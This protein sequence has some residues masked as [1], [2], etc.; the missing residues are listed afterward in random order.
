MKDVFT[1]IG[2]FSCRERYRFE[3]P[4]QG[5]F[6]DN[7]GVIVLNDDPALIEAC[8][9]LV[10]VERSWV[11]F[12]FHLNE[13]W[14]SMVR[15]PVS[16]DGRKVSVFA[17]RS[18]H[19][20]NPIGLSC[21]KLDRVE[22]RKLYIS[23]YDLL[24]ATPILDIK[25]YIPQADSF[26]DSKV[27]WLDSATANAFEVAFAD[28]AREKIDFILSCGGPDLENFSFVQLGVDPINFERKRLKQI[29]EGRWSIGCRTWQIEFS[30]G[31]HRVLV[32]DICSNY[33]S[34]DLNCRDDIYRDKEI[35]RRFKE[36]FP[37]DKE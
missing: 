17:T 12:K 37:S 4:R 19:R 18:P 23:N 33:S 14:K 30:C 32:L 20:P 6:A 31:D 24:D 16:P 35:H 34:D 15:P 27:P 25:P 29:G 7:H 11:I 26:P 1:P 21:V 8:A 2:Y 10:G 36:K 5:V 22:G 28:T 3:T 13:T 9:D